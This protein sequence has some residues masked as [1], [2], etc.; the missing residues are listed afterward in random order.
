[1]QDADTGTPRPDVVVIGASAGGVEALKRMI[2]ALPP[3][4]PA[5]V[6]LTLHLAD[7]TPS[8][9]PGDPGPGRLD[10]GAA[11]PSTV[12]PCA[13]ASSTSP[14]PTPTWP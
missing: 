13:P 8:L 1:V 14:S 7:D 4:C 12:R 5:T 11:P 3:T 10:R 9:L 6:C 2:A